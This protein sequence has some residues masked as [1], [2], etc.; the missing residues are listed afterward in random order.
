MHYT[1]NG[2]PQTDHTKVGIYYAQKPPKNILRQL[3]MAD[4]SI[5]IPAGDGLH[6]ERAYVQFPADVMLYAVR[7]HAHSRAYATRLTLRMPDGKETILHNQ[8]RYDFNWQREYIFQDWMPIPK[9]SILIADYIYDNSENN[10][11]NPNPKKDVV[12]G[13]QTFDEMLF[14]YVHYRI[15]GEDREHPRDDIQSQITKS[16]GFS[17]LDD[18]I[19]G[20]IQ[21]EELRGRR[22]E[23]LKATF[24]QF[25]LNHDGGL[26]QAEYFAAA[27]ARAR[28]ADVAAPTSTPASPAASSQP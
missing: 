6:H 14:T 3:G 20:K 19:D 13:E 8:P 17:V 26:D 23:R 5:E 21:P 25:D 12:F 22:F 18:N 7:P 1:P 27:G 9:G 2:K 11:S 4:F 15:V 10:V 28:A 24:D 16:L